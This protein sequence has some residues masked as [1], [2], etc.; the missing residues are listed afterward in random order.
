MSIELMVV[1]YQQRKRAIMTNNVITPTYPAIGG[2]F[3]LL[4]LLHD[5]ITFCDLRDGT[6]ALLPI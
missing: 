2:L 6:Q 4:A 5:D 3:L 1:W